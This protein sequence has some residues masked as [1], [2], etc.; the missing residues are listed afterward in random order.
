MS[1]LPV[2]FNGLEVD[3]L[4]LGDADCIVVT[5]WSNSYPWRVLIDGGSGANADAVKEFLRSR[6]Q[7]SFWAVLCTHA[8]ND[9][10][11]GLIKVI[12]DPSFTFT[13]GWMHDI[14][15]HIGADALRR[16]SAASDGVNEVVETTKELASAFAS[17]GITPLEPFAG[18]GIATWPNMSVLGPSV[19]YY[20]GVLEEFTKVAVP[21][22]V[23]SSFSPFWT[24]LLST[25]TPPS[26]FGSLIPSSP[27]SALADLLSGSLE[28][29][30]VK[31]APTTQ[32]FNNTSAVLGVIYMGHRLLFT[33]DAGADA[34]DLIPADW[35]GLTWMQVPHHASG[36]NLSQKNIER[37]CPQTANISARGDTSHP[38][39][40]IVNGLIKVGAKVYSTHTANP[41]HLWYSL[42]TVPARSDYGPAEPLK[43]TGGMEPLD[44]I[45]ILASAGS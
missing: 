13:Y 35:K 44:F 33:A 20:K 15:K 37:F 29:S 9:H 36:D 19:T 11:R 16:A 43:A 32:P 24:T 30:S 23:P 39:R 2:T 45:S 42:G 28:N 27:R 3:M 31:E 40:A 5:Q 22:P 38:S 6:G 41:G 14:R 7:T 1:A 25:P 4:S 34:L 18:W 17:R 8:H 21:I 26:A 10:A 12:Q